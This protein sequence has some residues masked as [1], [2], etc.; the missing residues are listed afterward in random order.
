MRRPLLMTAA[1]LAA[2]L[3]V[4][5]PASAHVSATPSEGASG[6]Y[7]RFA[8]R[9]PHGCDGAPTDE[10]AI[11]MPAGVVSVKPEF[12]PGWDAVA[13][14]GPYDEPVEL[15]GEELTEGVQSVTWTAQPGQEL[16]DDHFREFGLSVKLPDGEAG[17]ALYF[18]TVQSC[19]DGSEIAWIEI[20][21]GDEEPE[22]PAPS[23]TLTTADD[24]HGHDA[25]DDEDDEPVVHD[26]ATAESAPAGLAAAEDDGPDALTI[27]ALAVGLLGLVVGGA[28]LAIARRAR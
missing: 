2:T 13:E 23:V 25:G 1:T 21:S 17:D 28:G 7:A 22:S 24:A 16:P 19:P 15:H 27:V 9:V 4:A 8:F 11:Q 26:T 3:L 5:G 14:I 6:G 12:V 10:V 20:P 18:P